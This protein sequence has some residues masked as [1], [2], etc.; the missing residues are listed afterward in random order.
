MLLEFEELT[1]NFVVK[2]FNDF[3][4]EFLLWNYLDGNFVQYREVSFAGLMF[5]NNG[6]LSVKL[7]VTLVSLHCN[8]IG[9]HVLAGK[10][11]LLH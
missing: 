7:T 2:K 4:N 9:A 8:I 10:P 11:S 3:Q 6:L 1:P 5:G